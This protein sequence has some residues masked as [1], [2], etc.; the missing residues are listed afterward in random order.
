MFR[1]RAIKQSHFATFFYIFLNKFE[2]F[3]PVH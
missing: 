3:L 2:T 1:R